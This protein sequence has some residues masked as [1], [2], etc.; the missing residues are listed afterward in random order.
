MRSFV[1]ISGLCL[2]L[3]AA[4]CVSSAI[5]RHIRSTTIPTGLDRDMALSAAASV[6]QEHGYTPS[7]TDARLGIIST[8]WRT[9]GGFAK[10]LFGYS[11][12]GRVNVSI[13]DTTLRVSG[14]YQIR[15]TDSPFIAILGAIARSNSEDNHS[16]GNRQH[17]TGWYGSSPSEASVKEWEQVRE[18]IVARLTIVPR[19]LVPSFTS[20]SAVIVTGDDGQRYGSP[21]A[22]TT[23]TLRD[24]TRRKRV[25]VAVVGFRGI[26]MDSL[27]VKILGDRLRAELVDTGYFLVV[28]RERMDA[29][30]NEQGFQQSGGCSS[31]ECI[32]EMGRMIGVSRIITGSVGLLGTTYTTTIRMIDVETG[33]IVARGSDDCHCEVDELLGGMKRLAIVLAN[34]VK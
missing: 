26:G 17:D 2:A 6:L 34:N 5:N 29:I 10:I 23:G 12:R 4:G 3:S 15:Q 16:R 25:R 27:H 8:E 20:R 1:V 28:E 22:V 19:T 13:S 18:E 14:D 32:V 9:G 24:T 31:D 30:L 33:E 11:S 7:L 21:R